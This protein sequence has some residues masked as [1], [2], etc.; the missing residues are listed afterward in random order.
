MKSYFR[1]YGPVALLLAGVVLVSALLTVLTGPVTATGDAYRVVTTTYPLYLAAKNIVGDIPGVTVQTLTGAP[2]GCLHDYQLSPADRLML[3]RADLVLLNGAGAETFLE[4]MT[5]PGRTVDTSVGI[6]LLC[7]D[8]HHEEEHAD[9]AHTAYNEHLWTSPWRYAAQAQTATKALATMDSANAAAYFVNGSA[10]QAAIG[11]VR[12]RL[13]VA[14]ERLTEKVCVTFHDSL[15]Y[16][17]D[18][19][20]LTVEL[21]L[22]VGEDAGLSA[23][24]LAAAGQ[25]LASYPEALLLYDNQYTIRYPAVDGQ[26]VPGRVLA[27]DTGTAGDGRLTDW[28]D[29]MNENAALLESLTEGNT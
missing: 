11:Q 17:A 15:A 16:L 14:A 24:D 13:Q 3:E 22:T 12:A 26:A 10:Y 8:H 19:L 20:G 2:A 29:A 4:N 6:D 21:A 28:L 5:L 18:D 25:L 9:H 23:G 7:G 27:L 1:H